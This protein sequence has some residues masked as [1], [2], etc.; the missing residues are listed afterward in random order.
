MASRTKS[1]RRRIFRRWGFDTTAVGAEDFLSPATAA[2][3]LGTDV[4]G[5]AWRI[6]RR[7]LHP[8]YLEDGTEGVTRASVE[9]ESHWQATAPWW[10]RL[11]RAVGGV[12]QWI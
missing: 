11:A 1:R 7:I 6:T 3:V 4:E 2:E 10:K 5:V 8:A 12:L 9:A